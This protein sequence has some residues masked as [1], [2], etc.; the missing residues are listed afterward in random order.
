MKKTITAT[1]LLIISIFLI[2]GCSKYSHIEKPDLTPEKITIYNQTIEDNLKIL[3]NETTEEEK[4]NAFMGIAVNSQLLGNYDDA[5]EYYE[6]V[7][8]ISPSDFLGL[9]NLA[10][11]YEKVEEYE[12]AAFYVKELHALYK[13]RQGVISDTI[14]ILVKNKE[15]DNAKL[16]LTEYAQNYQSLETQGFI[17]EK[18]DYILRMKQKAENE[19]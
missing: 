6:K 16:V 17:S 11:L 13:G 5:I 15:F 9:N 4:F 12:L 1:A 2:A 10:A 14:R 7:L 8:E 18:F 19:N 3:D